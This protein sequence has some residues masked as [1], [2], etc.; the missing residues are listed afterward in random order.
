MGSINGIANTGRIYMQYR[1][2]PAGLNGCVQPFLFYSER[3][4]VV[5]RPNIDTPTYPRIS[6]VLPLSFILLL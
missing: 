4:Q 3:V 1:R 2:E 5:V 6:S